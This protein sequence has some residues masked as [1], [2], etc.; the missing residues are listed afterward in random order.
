MGK[1]L[2]DKCGGYRKLTSFTFAT[3]I[4]LG[5]IQF[6]RRFISF[7]DDPL[8]KTTGQMIG[9]ARSGR[10]NLIEGSERASTSRETEMKLTDVARAS[11]A[12]LLGDYE[13]FLAERQAVPWSTHSPEYQLVLQANPVA[14]EWSDDVMHDYWLYFQR[15]RLR[16]SPWLDSR[17]PLVVANTMI[18]LLRRTMAMLGSLLDRQGETFLQD[19]GFRERLHQ[20]RVEARAAASEAPA[21]PECGKPMCPRKAATGRSAGQAFWGCTAYPACKGTRPLNPPVPPSPET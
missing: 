9:A 15:E 7:R 13:I 12:E 17:D 6:C 20:G 14:F 1:P 21:C 11:L 4:H 16:F 3:L 18:I 5:T 2:F 8:G 10:Q 19:G